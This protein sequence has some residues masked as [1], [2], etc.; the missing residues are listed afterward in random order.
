VVDEF[1]V[2][3]KKFRTQLILSESKVTRDKHFLD[4]K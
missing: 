2:L 3:V 4:S 1:S